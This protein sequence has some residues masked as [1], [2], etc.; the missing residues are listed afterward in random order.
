[1]QTPRVL[2]RVPQ[3][4]ST[5][6]L[7]TGLSLARAQAPLPGYTD[8]LVNGFQD[9]RWAPHDYANT[10]PVHSGVCSIA[11]TFASAWDGLQIYRPD[12]DSNNAL[13]AGGTGYLLK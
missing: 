9:W 10:S 5:A 4:R 6:C 8:H 7:R 2:A 11:V 12:F 3:L 1:M 13:S